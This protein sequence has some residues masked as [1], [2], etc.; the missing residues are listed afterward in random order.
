[1]DMCAVWYGSEFDQ[2]HV[3]WLITTDFAL[4]FFFYFFF[5]QWTLKNHLAVIYSK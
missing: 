3:V 4:L 2:M 5:A 1:M